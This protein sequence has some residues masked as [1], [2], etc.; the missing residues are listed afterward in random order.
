MDEYITDGSFGKLEIL[1]LEY[2]ATGKLHFSIL[3]KDSA[4]FIFFQDD[5]NGGILVVIDGFSGR[6]TTNI[7]RCLNIP[8]DGGAIGCSIAL[9]HV[10][11]ENFNF[12]SNLFNLAGP[13]NNKLTERWSSMGVNH[14]RF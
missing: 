8:S 12:I 7:R 14:I 4:Q 10:R 1:D 13:K 2:N 6:R 11:F 5:I 3:A 9:D